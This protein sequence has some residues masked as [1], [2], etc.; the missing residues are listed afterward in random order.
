MLRLRRRRPERLK[1][2]HRRPAWQSGGRLRHHLLQ[3]VRITDSS[4]VQHKFVPLCRRRIE[5]STYERLVPIPTKTRLN[6]T[7][8]SLIEDLEMHDFDSVPRHELV[9]SIE[10]WADNGCGA[11]RMD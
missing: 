2:K 7:R 1:M 9:K 3:Q 8:G 6:E 10:Q 5:C 4:Q 11:Q